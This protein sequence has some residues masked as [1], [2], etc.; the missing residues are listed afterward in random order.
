MHSAWDPPIWRPLSLFW[1][2]RGYTID[3]VQRDHKNRI[4]LAQYLSPNDPH[5]SCNSNDICWR[6][7][8]RAIFCVPGQP[9]RAVIFQY[10]KGWG[11]VHGRRPHRRPWILDF[12]V[13]ILR[14]SYPKSYRSRYVT[15][16]YKEVC[17]YL[18][19]VSNQCTNFAHWSGNSKCIVWCLVWNIQITWIWG[20]WRCWR[21]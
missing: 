20:F 17:K 6:R 2:P 1:A 14:L 18:P 4:T 15:V 5:E 13:A 12:G 7:R 16:R 21:R 3:E 9:D 11:P 8:S 10:G 19:I